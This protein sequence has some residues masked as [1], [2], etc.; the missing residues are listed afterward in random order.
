MPSYTLSSNYDQCENHKYYCPTKQD[1]FG[2]DFT[3]KYYFSIRFLTKYNVP[4]EIG[5]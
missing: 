2:I 4:A 1:K 3:N 5:K